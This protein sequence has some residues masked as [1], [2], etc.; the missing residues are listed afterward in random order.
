MLP[1]APAA[2]LGEGGLDLNERLF[3]ALATDEN[4]PDLAEREYLRA[5]HGGVS[6]RRRC[7][8]ASTG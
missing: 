4:R 2:T 5:G 7:G 1:L 8:N 3:N 6:R